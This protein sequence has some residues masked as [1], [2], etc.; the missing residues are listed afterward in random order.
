MACA[1]NAPRIDLSDHSPH[2][3][4]AVKRFSIPIHR[5]TL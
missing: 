1:F 2:G 5:N 3:I 4:N